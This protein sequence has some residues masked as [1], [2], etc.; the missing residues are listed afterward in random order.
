MKA[1]LLLTTLEDYLKPLMLEEDSGV[2]S[3][4]A[5]AQEALEM[6]A[7][8]APTRWRLVLV[9]GGYTP[10][11]TDDSGEDFP[12]T[13]LQFFVQL[14]AR[15]DNRPSDELHRTSPQGVPPMLDRIELVLLW[16]RRVRLDIPGVDCRQLRFAGCGWET[17]T[18]GGRPL[19][20]THRMDFKVTTALDEPLTPI[21]WPPDMTP[22]E[23]GTSEE[24]DVM[25]TEDGDA[26]IVGG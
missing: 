17:E 22:I 18:K 3:V 26:V 13:E 12:D 19:T 24:G 14:P 10:T 23:V 15:M 20:R 11:D 16:L 8:N 4:A 7:G 1:T 9:W 25:T 21:K 6:L 2:F 5:D